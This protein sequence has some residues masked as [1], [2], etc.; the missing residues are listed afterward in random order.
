VARDDADHEKDTIPIVASPPPR[1][2]RGRGYFLPGLI[3]TCEWVFWFRQ[4]LLAGGLQNAGSRAEF[5]AAIKLWVCVSGMLVCC[6]NS[7]EPFAQA[8]RLAKSLSPANAHS[9]A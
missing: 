5:S 3:E 8:A 7:R 9:I 2:A 6:A 1:I 4:A